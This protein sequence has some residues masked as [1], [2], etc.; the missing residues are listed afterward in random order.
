MSVHPP[1]PR[2]C[3]VRRPEQDAVDTVVLGELHVHDLA[4]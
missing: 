3:Q 2:P 4:A 1:S